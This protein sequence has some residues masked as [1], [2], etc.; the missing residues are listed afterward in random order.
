MPK[1][2]NVGAKTM[3]NETLGNDELHLDLNKTINNFIPFIRSKYSFK[4]DRKT[5][6]Q[7]YLALGALI[8]FGIGDSITGAFMMNFCGVGAESNPIARH[9]METQGGIG[10]VLFKI[11]ATVAL[12][13]VVIAVQ[14]SSAEPMYWTTN[15]FLFSFGVGGLLATG[16]NLMRTFQFD[17]LEIGIPSPITVI[18]IYLGLTAILTTYGSVIDNRTEEMRKL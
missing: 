8:T 16:A 9:I 17:V 3:Q 18:C 6:I 11:W 13:T 10:L 5:K 7:L 12:L 2:E 1:N 15:G 14:R 4:L